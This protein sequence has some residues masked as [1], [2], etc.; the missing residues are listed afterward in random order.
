MWSEGYAVR[1]VGD[2]AS[3]KIKEYIYINRC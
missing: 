3:A 1:T 2:V